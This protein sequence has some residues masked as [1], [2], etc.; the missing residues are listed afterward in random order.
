MKVGV[1][2]PVLR[3]HRHAVGDIRERSIPT[4]EHPTGTRAYGWRSRAFA[5]QHVLVQIT[6]AATDAVLS[7]VERHSPHVRILLH[8]N[9][10]LTRRAVAVFVRDE[11]RKHVFAGGGWRSRKRAILAQRQAP[12]NI[13]REEHDVIGVV[14]RRPLFV[15]IA[16]ARPVAGRYAHERAVCVAVAIAAHDASVR[17]KRHGRIDEA[18]S[19]II[20]S[21]VPEEGHRFTA[22]LGDVHSSAALKKI[23]PER[24]NHRAGLEH[25]QRRRV[26]AELAIKRERAVRADPELVV[27]LAVEREVER[28]RIG[29]GHVVAEEQPPWRIDVHQVCRFPAVNVIVVRSARP[30]VVA[31]PAGD[32][33]LRIVWETD[34]RRSES[35]RAKRH[36]SHAPA[37]IT[38]A[39]R[40]LACWIDAFH[41]V[42]IV[43]LRCGRV[44]V[45][46]EC[47]RSA[48]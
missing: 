12:R 28:Q 25:V 4:V 30:D 24:R 29:R 33:E 9:G 38:C 46:K 11:H 35:I 2:A 39:K 21:V 40:P 44:I 5:E 47:G 17:E 43:G 19:R 8:R 41:P 36:R 3:R 45:K 22:V 10:H 31:R 27:G 26:S 20:H 23:L 34:H 14:E 6:A 37:R 16:E 48:N 7:E 42:P 32:G 13:L 1:G 18:V 15:E